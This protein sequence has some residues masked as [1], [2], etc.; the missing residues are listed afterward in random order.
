MNGTIHA[1]AEVAA[2]AGHANTAYND[3]AARRATTRTPCSSSR[4]AQRWTTASASTVNLI[5]EPTRETT[6]ASVQGRLLA[7]NGAVTLDSNTITR[8]DCTTEPGDDNTTT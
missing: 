2:Q 1:A 3:L 7:L 4:S 5:T 6:D 8:P